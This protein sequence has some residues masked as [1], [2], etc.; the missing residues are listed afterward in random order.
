MRGST[1]RQ[2][3]MFAVA[4]PGDL[5]P[6]QHPI[7][8]IRPF[9]EAALLRLEPTFEEIRQGGPALAPARAAA[10]QAEP[11]P[12][13]SRI[14]FSSRRLVEAAARRVRKALVPLL[15]SDELDWERKASAETLG[16]NLQHDLWMIS[17][18][19]SQVLQPE[20]G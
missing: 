9:V 7:R 1:A 8:R 3:T 12:A 5:I 15:Q 14:C 17:P 18:R 2:T 11:Q 19:S 4:D 20:N 10:A 13:I 6:E 16:E